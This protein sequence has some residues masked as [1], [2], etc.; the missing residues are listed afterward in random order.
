[1]NCKQKVIFTF[2]IISG[3]I[4]YYPTKSIAF[5]KQAITYQKLLPNSKQIIHILEVNPTLMD[6]KL[7]RAKD[8]HRSRETV[9]NI[10][11]HYH[12]IAA[13]NGGY[14][15]VNARGDGLPAGLLKIAGQLHGIAYLA[16][17][18][19]GWDNQNNKVLIDKIQTKT[20]ILIQQNLLP[21]HGLN[22]PL[23]S[24]R[25][26][27][28]S[29][30]FDD[31]QL[32]FKDAVTHF[33]IY[34]NKITNIHQQD[35]ITIPSNGYIYSVGTNLITKLPTIQIGD[36]VTINASIIPLLE[37]TTTSI[38]QQLPFI[39]GGGP[40]L[41]KNGQINHDYTAEKLSHK[42]ITNRY[43][44]TAVGILANGNWLL[45][46][47]E[48]NTYNHSEGCTISELAQIMQNLGCLD[49][50]NLDG[51]GSATMYFANQIVNIPPE[52]PNNPLNIISSRKVS[53]AIIILNK[54]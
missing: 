2:I 30:N 15:R 5:A 17:A 24:K 52:Y 49:A 35:H 3:V 13:I 45:V 16:R 4:L 51:G 20:N 34:H 29:D 32:F 47:A 7:V 43:A 50:L 22:V 40:L 26:I 21:I 27:L 36:P 18:A 14:F 11:K 46:T 42:F 10:A 8:F 53:D 31:N 1:M 41:I 44:R 6:I 48:K 38:W 33:T 39:L 28:Y 37:P 54:N 25:A 19:I 12:A 9:E 23:T